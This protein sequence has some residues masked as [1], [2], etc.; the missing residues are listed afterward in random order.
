MEYSADLF[1]SKKNPSPDT[2]YRYEINGAFYTVFSNGDDD[3]HMAREDKAS[4]EER[5][6]FYHLYL[7]KEK[8][9]IYSKKYGLLKDTNIPSDI[10]QQALGLPVEVMTKKNPYGDGYVVLNGDEI[11][12]RIHFEDDLFRGYPRTSLNA[13]ILNSNHPSVIGAINHLIANGFYVL[14]PERIFDVD[15]LNEVDYYPVHIDPEKILSHFLQ[16]KETSH[17]LIM[18]FVSDPFLITK[19]VY[20]Q[21][22]RPLDDKSLSELADIAFARKIDKKMSRG[23]Q[24]MRLALK[25]YF[26][27]M[28]RTLLNE[29]YMKHYHQRGL[30]GFSVLDHDFEGV[31]FPQ[32]MIYQGHH[33]DMYANKYRQFTLVDKEVRQSYLPQDYVLDKDDKKKILHAYDVVQKFFLSHREYA[34][35]PSVFLRMLG[36]PYPAFELTKYFDFEFGNKDA[37]ID[38]LTFMDNI[39]YK[40]NG[41]ILTL[42]LDNGNQLSMKYW[43]SNLSYYLKYMEKLGFYISN[44]YAFSS[45]VMPNFLLHNNCPNKK[46]QAILDGEYDAYHDALFAIEEKVSQLGNTAGQFDQLK[47]LLIRDNDSGVL[48]SV[49]RFFTLLTTGYSAYEASD[50]LEKERPDIDVIT[51]RILIN[52]AMLFFFEKTSENHINALTYSS[53]ERVFDNLNKGEHFYDP[54][55]DYP[56]V[57]KGR[58]FIAYSKDQKNFYFDNKDKEAMKN[59][60]EIFDK[61]FLNKVMFPYTLQVFGR[62]LHYVYDYVGKNKNYVRLKFLGLPEVVSKTIDID[63]DI[64]SQ[65][66]FKNNISFFDREDHQKLLAKDYS[67]HYPYIF[68]EVARKGCYLNGRLDAPT[69]IYCVDVEKLDE[70]IRYYLSLDF[71]RIQLQGMTYNDKIGDL[72]D[73]IQHMSD[74]DF[75]ETYLRYLYKKNTYV[76]M[77]EDE[78]QISDL[79]VRYGGKLMHALYQSTYHELFQNEDYHH[80]LGYYQDQDLCIAPGH[81]YFA[82]S[83]SGKLSSFSLP[84]EDVDSLLEVYQVL[85]N[86]FTG[87][88]SKTIKARIITYHL[89]LPAVLQERIYHKI[90]EN[91]F[92]LTKKDIPCKDWDIDEKN[93]FSY[94]DI[95]SMHKPVFSDFFYS[96]QLY[97]E[98]LKEGMFVYPD[99]LVLNPVILHPEN[100]AKDFD[101]TSNTISSSYLAILKDQAGV[102]KDMVHPNEI[103]FYYLVKDFIQAYDEITDL[104]PE[105]LFYVQEAFIYGY[106]KDENFIASAINKLQNGHARDY[107]KYF[108]D[109]YHEFHLKEFQHRFNKESIYQ[110]LTFFLVYLEQ[111]ALYRISKKLRM[112]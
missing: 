94:N 86:N 26:L 30:F 17:K 50:I 90:L 78:E 57:Y 101:S 104:S 38:K 68:R 63:K 108:R 109:I 71:I 85:V 21:F 25:R 97:H 54:Y 95:C 9:P 11:L 4:L 102:I 82:Y 18:D 98:A 75:E 45:N 20:Y 72:G 111:Q 60:L 65:L 36:L 77:N 39:D 48:R 73:E 8:Y 67:L 107:I 80:Y 6:H 19:E 12:N 32:R 33:Y 106:H 10:F 89:G 53:R 92:H 46:L 44:I 28:I 37:F 29:F 88:K 22:F 49:K 69:T 62:E 2:R 55:L 56:E 76:F 105:F 16:I 61:Y 34:F 15:Q 35:I 84:K 41:L 103:T 13:R 24:E 5:I 70:N 1:T 42:L 3:Y 100:M 96:T 47:T 66:H 79:A 83:K 91:D 7:S 52:I 99:T 81:C 14:N 23:E 112:R 93:H 43:P 110:F 74:V 58:N 64:Y 51:L 27:S 59:L 40:K 31:N 87:F